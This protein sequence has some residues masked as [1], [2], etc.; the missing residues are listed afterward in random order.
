MNFLVSIFPVLISKTRLVS[1]V[2]LQANIIRVK[3]S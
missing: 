2:L 3:T 1:T